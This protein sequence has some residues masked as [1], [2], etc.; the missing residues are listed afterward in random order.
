ME[1]ILWFLCLLSD[2]LSDLFPL[3]QPMV[4]GSSLGKDGELVLWLQGCWTGQAHWT[5]F[6]APR[7]GSSGCCVFQCRLAGSRQG[8]QMPSDS[9]EEVAGKLRWWQEEASLP[10]AIILSRGYFWFWCPGVR[11]GMVLGEVELVEMLLPKLQRKRSWGKG[12]N[13]GKMLLGCNLQ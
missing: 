9:L 13:K 5:S 1:T 10:P 6:E 4:M 2:P 8:Q 3:Q 7:W 12:G 11:D